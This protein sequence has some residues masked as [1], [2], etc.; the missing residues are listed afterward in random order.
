MQFN[1][2]IQYSEFHSLNESAWGGR[3]D[4]PAVHLR[5]SAGS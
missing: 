1:R 4:D 3:A 5:L 2:Q